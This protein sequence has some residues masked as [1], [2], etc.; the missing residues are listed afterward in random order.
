[1]DL[2]IEGRNAEEL[3]WE[4]L[5]GFWRLSSCDGTV[6]SVP[7]VDYGRVAIE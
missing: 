7:F 2:G 4:R 3:Q 5:G 1:M 6:E